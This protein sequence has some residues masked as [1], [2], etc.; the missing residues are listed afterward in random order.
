MK[1]GT[2]LLAG[3][4]FLL[5]APAAT[6]LA[7]RAGWR[8]D[9]T[10]DG[11]YSLSDPT[12]DLLGRIEQPI[13]L[14][15][16]F[17]PRI[18]GIPVPLRT[19]ADRVETLLRR[20][21]EASGGRVSV[22]VAEPSPDTP[23]EE[24]AIRAGL[25]GQRMPGGET[26]YFGLAA[27][28]PGGERALPFLFPA[29]EP[30]L[31]YDIAR[32]LVDLSRP[33]KPRIGILT[34]L[35]L[36]GA[37]AD[38]LTGRRDEPDSLL[39]Q[40]LN[41]IFEVVRIGRG[42]LPEDLDL[43]ALLH[44]PGIRDE[45]AYAIDQYFLEGGPLLVA[46]DPSAVEVRRA[47]PGQAAMSGLG[48]PTQSDLPQLLAAWG[49]DYNP[50][51]VVGDFERATSVRL[52]PNDPEI[53]HPVWLTF[54]AF[55]AEAPVTAGLEEILLAEPGS[56]TVENPDLRVTPI[57]ETSPRSGTMMASAVP[58]TPVEDIPDQIQPDGRSELIAALIQG[59]FPSAF[60]DGP[61]AGDELEAWINELNAAEGG[62]LSQS[63]EESTLLLITDTDLFSERFGAEKV[64]ALGQTASRRV[65]DNLALAV[66]LFDFLGGGSELL[67]LRG[68]GTAS[69][70][71]LRVET[72][73]AEARRSYE[74][75]LERLEEEIRAVREDIRA[76]EEPAAERGGPE[77][78]EEEIAERI[79]SFREQESRLRQERREIRRELREEIR[80]LD[81]TLALLNLF[82]VPL[83]VAVT[84]LAYFLRR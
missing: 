4:G 44:P 13:A 16:Y 41:R 64:R 43:L 40:E 17:T 60:P 73:T 58:I 28:G 62:A 67:G 76:W 37:R 1:T 38:P 11:I 5:L 69:R 83:L 66:N 33:D 45:M 50:R 2:K 25:A 32:L 71:F 80:A 27:A 77:L 65:N 12:R 29:R 59:V 74:T 79:R 7:D 9:W 75:Q 24:A 81:R 54:R 70:P 49:I 35:D 8:A 57:L 82:I 68:K 14:T 61:P 21:A 39:I 3:L 72:L 63:K 20:F 55:G 34:T 47:R 48:G 52:N 26:L 36:W 53:R 10:E 84:A 31:E 30:A 56:F 46:L 78:T 15:L 22:S 23:V 51:M 6:F 42:E 19:F 18:E